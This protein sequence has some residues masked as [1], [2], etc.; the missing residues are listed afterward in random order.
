MTATAPPRNPPGVIA[1][2]RWFCVAMF[3]G[4]CVGG[5]LAFFSGLEQRKLNTEAAT[6]PI[7]E[8]TVTRGWV[9]TIQTKTGSKPGLEYRG[10]MQ[11][12]MIDYT[13]TAGGQSFSASSR[14]P[15]QV[16]EDEGKVVAQTIA[17]SYV[18]GTS[19]PVHYKPDDPKIS[20]LCI[21]EVSS[22]A[23][24]WFAITGALTVPATL[25]GIWWMIF[26]FE[27]RKKA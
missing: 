15:R 2:T 13:F 16:G 26:R 22:S 25:F 18:P 8:G 1:F 20:R 27:R 14:G 10:E 23:W 6:W 12:V 4:L 21:V 5:V 11:E 17:D 3:A 24:L 7:A 19:I 9:K